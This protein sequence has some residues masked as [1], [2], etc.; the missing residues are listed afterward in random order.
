MKKLQEEEKRTKIQN[1]E[2]NNLH[3]KLN[4]NIKKKR[5]P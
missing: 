3:V 5:K 4:I 1:Y 2:K